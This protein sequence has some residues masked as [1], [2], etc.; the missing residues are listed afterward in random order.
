M[1]EKKEKEVTKKTEIERFRERILAIK[2]GED[3]SGVSERV[4][5]EAMA[6]LK[7]LAENLGFETRLFS[8]FGSDKDAGCGMLRSEYVGVAADGNKTQENLKKSLDILHYSTN[9]VKRL[10]RDTDV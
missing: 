5:L 10:N 2:D 7:E 8:S 1:S 4:K 9:H 6:E 3:P